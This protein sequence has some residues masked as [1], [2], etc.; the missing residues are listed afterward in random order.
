[1]ST[2]CEHIYETVYE[3]AYVHDS[4]EQRLQLLG[5]H[6]DYSFGIA[7]VPATTCART[8]HVAVY[9]YVNVCLYILFVQ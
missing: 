7:H 3:S 4:A 8:R 9:S 6:S 5:V 2:R 1:M